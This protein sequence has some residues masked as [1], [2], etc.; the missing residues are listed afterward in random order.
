MPEL[1]ETPALQS[2]NYY[3]LSFHSLELAAAGHLCLTRLTVV[4][5]PRY[6]RAVLWKSQ[7]S[8]GKDF[9]DRT[10]ALL[11]GCRIQIYEIFRRGS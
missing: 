3:Q 10:E 7:Y 11:N 1:A 2:K 6:E 5:V 8:C 4:Q 9:F